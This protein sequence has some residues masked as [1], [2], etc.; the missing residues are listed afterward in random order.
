MTRYNLPKNWGI[1]GLTASFVSYQ[2]ELKRIWSDNV[3]FTK[4]LILFQEK[5]ENG[6]IEHYHHQLIAKI[7]KW[8]NSS[9]GSGSKTKNKIGG[10]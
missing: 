10:P 6:T 8:N 4:S 1:W 7:P 2:D 3:A 5:E 9:S